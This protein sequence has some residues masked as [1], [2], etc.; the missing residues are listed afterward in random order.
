MMTQTITTEELQALLEAGP[1]A[2]YDVRG[3]VDY[4]KG[5]IPAAKTAPPGSLSFRVRSVMNPD[6]RVVVY[7][8]GGDCP[9]AADAAGRL[10]NLGMRNVLVYADGIAGW[11]DAGHEVVESVSAKTHARG[12]VIE[13]RP[14]IVDRE[15]AYGGAFKGK[16][17]DTESAG[18]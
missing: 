11:R 4:E 9:L 10:A 6:T 1:L 5:H 14:L 17:S 15:K 12:E 3:D 16:P 18:G 8:N 7:S 13:V 2:L